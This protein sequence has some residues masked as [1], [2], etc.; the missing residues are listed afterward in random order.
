[1][2]APT[3]ITSLLPPPFRAIALRETGDAFAHACA[4][5]AAE[6]AGTLV[7]T[8]RFD[9]IELALVLEPEEP[10]RL[11]RRSFLVGMAAALA[12]LRLHLPPEHGLTAVWPGDILVDGQP[13][14]RGRLGW[15][16][17]ADE[18]QVP[19]W[20]VF[21][22]EINGARI[23]APDGAPAAMSLEEAG[24]EDFDGG[25]FAA[26][27]CRQMLLAADRLT[28]D[29]VAAA[30]APFLDLI[31]LGKAGSRAAIAENGDLMVAGF[32]AAAPERWALAPALA[33]AERRHG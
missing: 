30:A 31:D 4:V 29:G 17:G 27:F 9:T 16:D 14:G 11:A 8:G 33:A 26:D 10:L 32:G 6:G 12:A 1:M 19:D 28:H 7:R 23:E 20:L 18:G 3:D 22:L 13:V 21:G 24:F 2:I 5:A 25:R 15:P